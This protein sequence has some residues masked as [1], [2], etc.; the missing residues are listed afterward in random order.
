M[1]DV[2]WWLK[3]DKKKKNCPQ[4]NKDM[5]YIPVVLE[6]YFSCDECGIIIYENRKTKEEV[7]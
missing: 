2:F 4:C 5:D 7:I 3:K 1:L 6:P